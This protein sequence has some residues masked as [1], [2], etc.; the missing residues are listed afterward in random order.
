MI[1]ISTR[2]TMANP[3]QTVWYGVVLEQV[4][5]HLRQ[6]LHFSKKKKGQWLHVT[7]TFSIIMFNMWTYEN[8]GPPRIP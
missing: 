3:T 5:N 7:C 6:C 2:L 4:T 1:I 8:S